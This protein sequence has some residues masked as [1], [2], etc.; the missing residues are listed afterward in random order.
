[1]KRT[2]WWLAAGL[3]LALGGMAA[4]NEPPPAARILNGGRM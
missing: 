1:M 4:G 3:W 2:A